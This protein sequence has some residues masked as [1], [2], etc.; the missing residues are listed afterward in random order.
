MET[1]EINNLRN[2]GTHGHPGKIQASSYKDAAK[3]AADEIFND[4]DIIAVSRETGTENEPGL[5]LAYTKDEFFSGWYSQVGKHFYVTGI[6]R[7]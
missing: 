1:Y 5:F 4:S 6:F 3:L 2:N 7:H